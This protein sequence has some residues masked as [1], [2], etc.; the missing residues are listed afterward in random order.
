MQTA[1]QEKKEVRFNLHNTRITPT[2]EKKWQ[3]AYNKWAN[4]LSALG[5]NPSPTKYHV[6]LIEQA[7]AH[8]EL[9]S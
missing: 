9:E 3:I 7:T 8:I 6:Y 2:L 5:G 4:E 1:T